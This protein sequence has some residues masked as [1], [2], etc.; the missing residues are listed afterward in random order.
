MATIDSLRLSITE[1]PYSDVVELLHVIRAN[2]RRRPEK[3]LRA[4]KST[5]AKVARAPKKS[6]LKQ[7]DIFA[8]TNG[9]GSDAKKKLAAELMKGLIG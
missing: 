1:M 6:N 4:Q 3:S 2:R 9:L 7:Q 8:Y 5:P